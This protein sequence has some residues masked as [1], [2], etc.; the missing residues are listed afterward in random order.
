MCQF[1]IL[2]HKGIILGTFLGILSLPG[3]PTTFL[4]NS[5]ESC[6]IPGQFLVHSW[7]IPGLFLAYFWP[8]SGL[9]LVYSWPF[10]VYS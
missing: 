6:H 8:I 5:W 1:E 9:F 3:I 4:V 10:L 2:S 7:P